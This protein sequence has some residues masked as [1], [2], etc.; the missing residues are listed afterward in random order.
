MEFK[1]RSIRGLSREW[2]WY[3]CSFMVLSVFD[4]FLA[5][6]LTLCC[7]IALLCSAHLLVFIVLYAGV[8]PHYFKVCL[9]QHA[10]H[11]AV[12]ICVLFFLNGVLTGE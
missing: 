9:C 8:G 3:A 6:S 10:Q 5:H 11:S 2:G 1:L 7:P 4:L 12:A